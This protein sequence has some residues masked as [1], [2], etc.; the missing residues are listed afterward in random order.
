MRVRDR[1]AELLYRAR[2]FRARGIDWPLFALVGGLATFL[3][4]LVVVV[5]NPN[6]RWTGLGWL[7]VGLVGYAVYRRFFVHAGFVET[8][9]APR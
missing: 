7:A 5:Q 6:A 1:D 4:W 3:S 2:N 9:R 8:V